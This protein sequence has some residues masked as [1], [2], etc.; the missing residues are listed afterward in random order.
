MLNEYS[1]LSGGIGSLRGDVMSHLDRIA[2]FVTRDKKDATLRQRQNMHQ[3]IWNCLRGIN[4]HY[5][6]VAALH[7]EFMQTEAQAYE[8]AQVN[9]DKA[10]DKASEKINEV[11]ELTKTF[12]KAL[13]Q[14]KTDFILECVE[15]LRAALNDFL[16]SHAARNERID[17]FTPEMATALRSPFLKQ[18]EVSFPGHF[19]KSSQLNYFTQVKNK[20][21]HELKY[22]I[23]NDPVDKEASD[24]I[25]DYFVSLMTPDNFDG[26]DHNNLIIQQKLAFENVCVALMSR[27]VPNPSELSVMRFYTSIDHFSTKKSA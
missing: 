11:I 12:D 8:Y 2:V 18:L 15:P 10:T 23:N 5:L 22:V 6:Q 7:S 21:I 1:V 26:T 3:C 27:G 24:R 4:Y 25:E 13:G 14:W 17:K 9:L 16:L 20:V 19:G